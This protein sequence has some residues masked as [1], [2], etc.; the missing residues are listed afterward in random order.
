MRRLL[1][2]DSF[3]LGDVVTDA[4]VDVL[5]ERGAARFSIAA[6]AERIGV[7]RQTL[8][9]RFQDNGG[10]RRRLIHL[11]TAIYGRRITGWTEAALIDD[12]P[13]PA[14]PVTDEERV[15]TRIWEAMI[16]LARGE[17]GA[18][19]PNPGAAVE[20]VR[21]SELTSVTNWLGV[22]VGHRISADEALPVWALTIGL[23]HLLSDP[24]P[25]V[26]PADATKALD[27]ALARFEAEH[28]PDRATA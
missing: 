11:V 16:E 13:A 22:R 4:A 15:D 14:L 21:R 8:T 24:I 3:D 2:P 17:Y 28:H 10:A 6:M 1:R 19:N 18:D 9:E 27:T 7:T 23:R 20:A 12:P 25:V 5:H 26:L